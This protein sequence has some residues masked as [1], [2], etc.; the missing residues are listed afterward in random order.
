M[1]STKKLAVRLR[2]LLY[3]QPGL[4]R[5]VG[6]GNLRLHTA[7][8]SVHGQYIALSH[9]RGNIPEEQK[10]IFCTSSDNI[11]NRCCP[12]KFDMAILTKAFQDAIIVTRELGQR[13]FWIGSLCIIQ[14][15]D[16]F[17]D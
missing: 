10:R 6:D 9:S 1:K 2:L 14:Y 17:E 4:V 15:S 8:P 3:Y 16:N 13:Y 11:I 12:H 5:G 7:E